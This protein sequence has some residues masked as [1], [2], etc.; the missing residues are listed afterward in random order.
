MIRRAP[1]RRGPGRGRWP[2]TRSDPAQSGSEGGFRLPVNQPADEPV[3]GAVCVRT[4]RTSARSAERTWLTVPEDPERAGVDARG[5]VAPGPRGADRPAR[6][7][8][9]RSGASGPSPKP[10]RSHSCDAGRGGSEFGYQDRDSKGLQFGR[11]RVVHVDDQVGLRRRHGG[12]R[13]AGGRAGPRTCGCGR[14]PAPG[15]IGDRLDGCVELYLAVA[16]QIRAVPG[17]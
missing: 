12:N 6:R 5:E 10:L 2:G 8:G 4:S 3:G 13:A 14:Q 11:L 9:G 1:L 15:A 17:K 16:G 7:R